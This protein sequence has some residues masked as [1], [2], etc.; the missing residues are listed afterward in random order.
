MAL[1]DVKIYTDGQAWRVEA[2]HGGAAGKLRHWSDLGEEN[3]LALANDLMGAD[4]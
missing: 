2:L 1:R 3:A 4:D